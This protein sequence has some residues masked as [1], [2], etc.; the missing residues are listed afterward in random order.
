[1]K[2]VTLLLLVAAL[3]FTA[4]TD[5]PVE[6]EPTPTA[7][8]TETVTA[9]PSS[10][11]SSE[12]QVVA[13]IG[14]ILEHPEPSQLPK[15]A[16]ALDELSEVLR[17]AEPDNEAEHND[18]CPAV[19]ET[20]PEVAG[21]GMSE[22]QDDEDQEAVTRLA[23]VGFATPDEAT[24]LT[25]QVQQFVKSCTAADYEL[26]TLTHHTDEAFEVRLSQDEEAVT[27]VVLV[28]NAN[29]V[30]VAASTPAADVALALTLVDQL[31]ETLR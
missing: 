15:G 14:N 19:F 9:D 10:A 11:L 27:S 1:M 20:Q 29:W 21:Y 5:Q 16:A 23:A 25:E 26:E 3:G 18:A 8:V 7:A 17:P 13:A 31:D 22:P 2:R 6:A 28:R 4:C 30:F 12:D 24:E